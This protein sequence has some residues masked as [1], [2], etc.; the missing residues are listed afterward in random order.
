MTAASYWSLLEPS[1]EAAKSSGIYG[2]DGEYAFIPVCIG[3]VAGS[4]FVV[5]ADKLLPFLVSYAQWYVIFVW[6]IWPHFSVD[7]HHHGFNPGQFTVKTQYLGRGE[8]WGANILVYKIGIHIQD[9]KMKKCL[10]FEQNVGAPHEQIFK[11]CR[12]KY[13]I[14]NAIK[15]LQLLSAKTSSPVH[16]VNQYRKI[17]QFFFNNFFYMKRTSMLLKVLM[18]VDTD[19]HRVEKWLTWNRYFK[20]QIAPE[21]AKKWRN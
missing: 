15:S 14:Y 10:N 9:I 8:K 13:K 17:L 11:K 6:E 21:V 16:T 4:S 20:V 12:P 18:N 3:F 7:I 5:I 19:M 2:A 1:I